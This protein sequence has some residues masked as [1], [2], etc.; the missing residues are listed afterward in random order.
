MVSRCKH[1]K[2][3]YHQ[4]VRM[5]DQSDN[6]FYSNKQTTESRSHMVLTVSKRVSQSVPS[7][8]RTCWKPPT[9]TVT[10]TPEL[11]ADTVPSS[12]CSQISV[13][14][15]RSTGESTQPDVSSTLAVNQYWLTWLYY[16][17]Q[18]WITWNGPAQKI[19]MFEYSLIPLLQRTYFRVHDLSDLS[20]HISRTW[21]INS[22]AMSIRD[23]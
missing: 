14:I 19:S 4:S 6:H 22:K 17:N 15:E 8:P 13:H 18:C 7:L 23:P 12:H 3:S 2:E 11:A 16:N 9:P 10:T 20:Y 1:T 21:S 5:R